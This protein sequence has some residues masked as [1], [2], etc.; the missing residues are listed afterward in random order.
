MDLSIILAYRF[1]GEDTMEGNTMSIV[2]FTMATHWLTL[3][4]EWYHTCPIY[5]P[6]NACFSFSFWTFSKRIKQWASLSH[7]HT[8][9]RCI[10][11]QRPSHLALFT[12]FGF[13]VSSTSIV[14]IGRGRICAAIRWH[15]TP[16]LPVTLNAWEHDHSTN[17]DNVPFTTVTMSTSVF[18]IGIGFRI[19]MVVVTT[20][21]TWTRWN[22]S[23]WAMAI[24]WA[25]AWGSRP[26][27]RRRATIRRRVVVSTH[28]T[29]K[30]GYAQRQDT[31]GVL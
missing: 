4:H 1:L 18:S 13:L 5:H 24:G 16:T 3:I 17:T 29:T 31:V 20:T 7:T 27:S 21:T 25:V 8:F 6:Q 15:W 26:V 9:N 22:G 30:D 12:L 28:N 2:D 14:F 10:I 11:P 23:T 19:V